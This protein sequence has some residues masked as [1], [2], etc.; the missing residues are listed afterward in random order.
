MQIV[1]IMHACGRLGEHGLVQMFIHV[2]VCLC[3]HS[4][5]HGKMTLWGMKVLIVKDG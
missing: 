4:H 3:L 5:M 1:S 2:S